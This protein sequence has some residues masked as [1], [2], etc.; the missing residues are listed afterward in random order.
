MAGQEA[1]GIAGEAEQSQRAGSAVAFELLELAL[2][3]R[4]QCHLGAGERSVDEYEQPNRPT[5]TQ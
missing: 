2:P 3:Q 1:V 5:S 4:Y